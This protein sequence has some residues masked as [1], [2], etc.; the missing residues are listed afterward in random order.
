[1][2][3]HTPRTER[4]RHSAKL[5]SDGGEGGWSYSYITFA[6]FRELLRYM[7]DLVFFERNPTVRLGKIGLASDDSKIERKC[8][9]STIGIILTVLSLVPPGPYQVTEPNNKT[10]T[11][12]SWPLSPP[13]A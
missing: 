4:P 8:T 7:V 10:V 13:L 12:A 3:T 11:K 5:E 6:E 2:K 9:A 1:M